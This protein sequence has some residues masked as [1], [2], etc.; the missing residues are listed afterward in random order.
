MP[1]VRPQSFPTLSVLILL[2]AAI[3]AG[4][5]TLSLPFVR[6]IPAGARVDVREK[7]RSARR[8]RTVVPPVIP[9]HPADTRIRGPSC[10][11]DG[12]GEEK[13]FEGIT[14]RMVGQVRVLRRVSEAVS[15]DLY[16]LFG[17]GVG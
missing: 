13:Q 2:W 16:D 5:R 10:P 8:I 11:V 1:I 3:R 9:V 15:V 12:S 4:G 6:F 14:G 7:P 17:R